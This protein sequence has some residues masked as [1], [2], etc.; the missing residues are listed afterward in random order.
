MADKVYALEVD[1]TGTPTAEV[2]VAGPEGPAYWTLEVVGNT[3]GHAG[4]DAI[5]AAA[6][7]TPP[8]EGARTDNVRA[9]AVLMGA[10]REETATLAGR[11][12]TLETRLAALEGEPPA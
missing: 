6:G 4:L 8:P 5:H 11:V 1:E 3:L 12:D 7:D 2:E 9:L 10:F